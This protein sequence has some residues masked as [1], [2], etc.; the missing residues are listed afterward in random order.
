MKNN[1]LCS[2]KIKIIICMFLFLRE[3]NRSFSILEDDEYSVK[4]FLMRN[5]KILFYLKRLAF[6]FNRISSITGEIK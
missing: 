1:S 4:K 6:L 3:T 5:F 2:Y